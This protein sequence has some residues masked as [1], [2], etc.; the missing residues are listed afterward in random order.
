MLFSRTEAGLN[1]VSLCAF[2]YFSPSLGPSEPVPSP[3]PFCLLLFVFAVNLHRSCAVL[4]CREWAVSQEDPRLHFASARFCAPPPAT[5]CRFPAPCTV[6][7][8]ASSRVFSSCFASPSFSFV[9]L[10][11]RA[12]HP[13]QGHV[14]WSEDR[15]RAARAH[16]QAATGAYPPLLQRVAAAE[17]GVGVLAMCT[18]WLACCCFSCCFSCLSCCCFELTHCYCSCCSGC[19]VCDFFDATACAEQLQ[20]ATPARSPHGQAVAKHVSLHQSRK[21]P[22]FLSPQPCSSASACARVC[23][24]VC[25]SVCVCVN[26]RHDNCARP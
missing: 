11:L 18:R 1:L 24:C 14:L 6:F 13:D 21:G 8:F 23:V 2:C 25:E 12:V 5:S 9:G 3:N 7:L 22:C 19:D 20:Q 26:L 16:G 15:P 4:C 10:V 17:L